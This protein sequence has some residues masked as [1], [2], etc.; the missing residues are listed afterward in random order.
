MRQTL[1]QL[2]GL[3][4]ADEE[5]GAIC[6]RR[7]L[8]TLAIKTVLGWL[9]RP[10]V[11]GSFGVI[12]ARSH[13]FAPRKLRQRLKIEVIDQSVGWLVPPEKLQAID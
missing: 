8:V 6:A 3:F 11:L 2:H 9:A 1:R 4:D 12:V 13:G 7:Q 5:R 10:I